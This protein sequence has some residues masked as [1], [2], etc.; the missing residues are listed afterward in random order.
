MIPTILLLCSIVLLLILA[1]YYSKYRMNK[2]IKEVIRIFRV[3]NALDDE[4]ARTKEEL[5]LMPPGILMRLMRQRDYKPYALQLLLGAEIIQVTMENKYF[6]SETRL[7]ASV[8]RK[9][10]G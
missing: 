7:A 3:K 4:S 2:A 8:F 1:Y 6:L 9:F 5:G 10:S